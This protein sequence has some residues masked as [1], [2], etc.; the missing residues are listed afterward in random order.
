MARI[1]AVLEMSFIGSTVLVL[2]VA[3]IHGLWQVL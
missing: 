2:C 3:S 1:H